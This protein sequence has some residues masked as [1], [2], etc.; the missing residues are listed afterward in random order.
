MIT[1]YA[2]LTVVEY[3]RGTVAGFSCRAEDGTLGYALSTIEQQ[4]IGSCIKDIEKFE[5]HDIMEFGAQ[6]VFKFHNVKGLNVLIDDL[7][8]LRDHMMVENDNNT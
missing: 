5:G 1:H 6:V 2:D 4:E 7:V 8:K 3:G